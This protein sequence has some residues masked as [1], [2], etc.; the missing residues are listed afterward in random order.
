MLR[1]GLPASAAGQAAEGAVP[2]KRITV[3]ALPPPVAFDADDAHPLGEVTD[4]CA[5]T[6]KQSPE[7]LAYLEACGIAGSAAAEA[8]DFFKLGYSNR[9]LALR[10]PEKNRKAGADRARLQLHRRRQRQPPEHQR[11]DGAHPRL[12]PLRPAGLHGH[13]RPLDGLGLR[14]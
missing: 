9:T 11:R 6:L 3:R 8:I 2:I 1:E 10:L 14:H 7:S 13:E 12:D 5:A 4:Y